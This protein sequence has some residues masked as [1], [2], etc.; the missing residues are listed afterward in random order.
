MTSAQSPAT[1]SVNSVIGRNVVTTFNPLFD[2]ASL[3][4]ELGALQATRPTSSEIAPKRE[5]TEAIWLQKSRGG[6]G[7]GES[8]NRVDKNDN[9]SLD[10]LHNSVELVNCH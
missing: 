4:V 1:A 2:V 9:H 7:S 10:M 6:F 5:K 8:L 3:L